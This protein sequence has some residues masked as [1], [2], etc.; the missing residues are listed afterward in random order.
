VIDLDK[1]DEGLEK[2]ALLS[3]PEIAPALAP[4]RLDDGSEPHWPRNPQAANSDVPAPLRYGFGWF[5]DPYQGH[6]RN[7]HDGGTLGFRTT[8]QRFISDRLTIII[9]CNRNDLNPN[10]LSLKV[11]DA[12]FESGAR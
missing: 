12:L 3:A 5:L 8:I 10:E 4:V 9:L 2:H 6:A 1:W 7:Y 11:A